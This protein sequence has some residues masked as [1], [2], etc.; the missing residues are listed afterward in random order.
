[1]KSFITC[2]LQ[3]SSSISFFLIS[4]S[5]QHTF[6]HHFSFDNSILK[7]FLLCNYSPFALT[8]GEFMLLGYLLTTSPAIQIGTY[9]PLGRLAPSE[10][11]WHMWPFSWSLFFSTF[12]TV[13]SFI[14]D[15]FT[16]HPLIHTIKHQP[17]SITAIRAS[18]H[19]KKGRLVFQ[20][21]SHPHVSSLVT[22]ISCPCARVPLAL[23]TSGSIC[24]LS[25][26]SSHLKG[27]I[28]HSCHCS[29]PAADLLGF[30]S[31]SS[32]QGSAHHLFCK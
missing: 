1:M 22:F 17:W 31:S 32:S 14:L 15:F 30:I 13:S 10:L 27:K 20:M 2:G 4:L 23:K 7:S 29:W 16:V 21:A 12:S 9:L 28:F 8:T 5:S 18:L 24:F 19:W 3:S 25:P 11:L 6:H 26:K